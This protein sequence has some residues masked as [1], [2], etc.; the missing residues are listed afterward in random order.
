MFPFDF[1]ESSFN[2]VTNYVKKVERVRRD[3]QTKELAK[4]SNKLVNFKGSYAREFSGPKL[5]VNTTHSTMHYLRVT[6]WGLY[7][8]IFHLFRVLCMWRVANKFATTLALIVR[9]CDT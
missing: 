1:L 4:K 2:K 9:T 3:G 6:I 7:L 8:I 5:V